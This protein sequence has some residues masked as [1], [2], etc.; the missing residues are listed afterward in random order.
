MIIDTETDL[1]AFGETLG[2]EILEK[3]KLP[4]V[5]ELIGDVGAGKT[6]LTRGLAKGLGV[7]EPVTSPS[8]SISKR[9]PV[10]KL[11]AELIHYDFYRLPDPGLMLSE[12]EETLSLENV[13]V[14]IEWGESVRGILPPTAKKI[15]L[16][17]LE[18]GGR[19]II[20]WKCF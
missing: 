11:D 7:L 9:Y 17:Y 1:I 5:F 14:V 8:F 15:T 18:N 6:T 20:L 4:V 19:G 3:R 13:I 16:N 2:K 12:L 10:P